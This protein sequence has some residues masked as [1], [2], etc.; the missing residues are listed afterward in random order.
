M[1]ERKLTLCPAK[2]HFVKLKKISYK[3]FCRMETRK[4]N[5]IKV[6]HLSNDCV[7]NDPS[8]AMIERCVM[9]ESNSFILHLFQC[10]GQLVST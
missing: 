3:L 9:R 10:T 5:K 1:A 6:E 8:D 7:R 4:V 2:G